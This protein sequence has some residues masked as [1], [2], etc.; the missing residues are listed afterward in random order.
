M[1]LTLNSNTYFASINRNCPIINKL[2]KRYKFTRYPI[3][4]LT[5]LSCAK[6]RRDLKRGGDDDKH[7]Q[8]YYFHDTKV[9]KIYE[10]CKYK[11][12]ILSNLDT[13]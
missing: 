11:Y 1:P 2:L 13:F 10:I 12:L 4:S 9:S 8:L 5:I 6:L 3:N 7:Y